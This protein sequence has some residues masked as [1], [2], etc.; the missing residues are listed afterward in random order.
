MDHRPLAYG[1]IVANLFGSILLIFVGLFICYCATTVI[2]IPT[3]ILIPVIVVFS[4]V[5]TY[6]IRNTL[7]DVKLMFFLSLIGWVL[8]I[9]D[10]PAIAVVLGVIL[11]PIVGNELLRTHQM[12]DGDM[13]VFFTRPI[14][15][16]LLLLA[17]LSVL[18]PIIR[19]KRQATQD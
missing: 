8:R 3:R 4:V 7:F 16:L 9:Y 14:S 13:T 10:Y 18:L 11:G 15:L 19:R 2:M 12:F 5:G 1:L 17:L 6:A